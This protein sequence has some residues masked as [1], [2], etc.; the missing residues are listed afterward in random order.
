MRSQCA[1]LPAAVRND[2]DTGGYLEV[3]RSPNHMVQTQAPE[4]KIIRPEAGLLVLF[5]SYI[6]HRIL[7]FEADDIR[8]SVAFDAVPI[9]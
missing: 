2:A 7:P 6:H 9:P 8:M 3:G 1:R 5:P 4:L